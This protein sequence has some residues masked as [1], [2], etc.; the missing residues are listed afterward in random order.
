MPDLSENSLSTVPFVS[1]ENMMPLVLE[2]GVEKAAKSAPCQ[3]QRFA[4]KDKIGN[5]R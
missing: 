1:V 3:F 4:A 2:T 5:D